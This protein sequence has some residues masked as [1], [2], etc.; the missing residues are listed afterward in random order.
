MYPPVVPLPE[1]WSE[2]VSFE[3][4]HNILYTPHAEKKNP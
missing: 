4:W 1:R 3:D 2:L